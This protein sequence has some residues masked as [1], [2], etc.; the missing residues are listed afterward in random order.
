MMLAAPEFVVAQR[1][2]LLDEIDDRGGTA[3]SDSRRSDDAGRER[4]RILAAA[5]SGSQ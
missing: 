4:R 1:I 2:E 5:W 3:A